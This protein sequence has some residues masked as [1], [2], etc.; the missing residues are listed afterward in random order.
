MFKRLMLVAALMVVTVAGQSFAAD[1]LKMIPEDADF[2]LQLN[3]SKIL[4]MPEV[5]KQINDGF[6]KEPERKKTYEELKGKTGFDPLKDISSFVLFSSGTVKDGAEALAGA[7]VEGKYDIEKITATIKEDEAFKKDA[8]LTVIDGFNAIVPKNTKDGYGMFLD[9]QFVAVGSQSGVDAIKAVKLGKA[10]NV[11]NKKDFYA[12]LSKLDTKATVCGAGLLPKAFKEK[13]AKNPNAAAFA[14]INLFRFDFNNDTNMVFN[15]SAEIDDAKNVETVMTQ[16]NGYVAM[17]KMFAA[18]EPAVAEIV[19][20]LNVAS[21]GT[22]V[23]MSLN[24]PAE[25][26]AELKA[27]LEEKAKQMQEQNKANGANAPRE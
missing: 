23:K 18:Q 16:L 11:E 26:L 1:F 15:L 19:N 27:K 5:Q 8:D 2:V 20:M 21:E 10:K 3:V 4:A 14:N 9:N 13:V 24:V 17:I 12:I 7:I 6:A 25:K 22:S